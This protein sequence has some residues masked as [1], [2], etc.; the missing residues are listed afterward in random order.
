MLYSRSVS[1]F[2]SGQIDPMYTCTDI[3]AYST[4]I[5]SNYDHSG[6]GAGLSTKQLG[7]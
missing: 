7:F 3:V 1:A 6:S 5:I 2:R 4:S